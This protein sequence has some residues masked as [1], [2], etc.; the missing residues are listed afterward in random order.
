MYA[1]ANLINTVISIYI[2]CLF[3]YIVMS[4]L[5][6]FGVINTGSRLVYTVMDVLYRITEPALRPIRSIIP[7]FGTVDLSPVV[8]VLLLIFVRDFLLVDLARMSAG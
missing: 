2:W 5:I 4:W 6:S 7:N 1:L 3:G 8:L